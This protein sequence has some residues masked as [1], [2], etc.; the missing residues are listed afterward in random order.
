[1]LSIAH[2]VLIDTVINN[3]F[4]QYINPVIGARPIA[5]FAYIH[6]R[7]QPYMLSPIE[8]FNTF[9]SIVEQVLFSFCHRISYGFL[10]PGRFKVTS[11]LVLTST[12]FFLL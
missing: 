5:K 6:P 2:S 12:V 10:R 3:F 11:G 4:E 9:F 1:M 8:T 7:T